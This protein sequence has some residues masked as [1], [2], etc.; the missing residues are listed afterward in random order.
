VYL[1]GLQFEVDLPGGEVKEETGTDATT[2]AMKILPPWMIKQ[3][4]NLT[5]EQRGEVQPESKMDQSSTLAD[6][7]KPKVEEED[8]KN[9]QASGLTEGFLKLCFLYSSCIIDCSC[10]GE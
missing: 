3:G 8:E 7:K 5:K 2:Q 10:Y 1:Y 4:M 6:E 9:I